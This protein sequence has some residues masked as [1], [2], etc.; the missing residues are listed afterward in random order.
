M[1]TG[2]S[3]QA[4]G[5]A[6]RPNPFTLAAVGAAAGFL[7]G[8]FGIGGG[9]IIVPALVLW[10]AVAQ[11]SATGTSTAAILPTAVVGTISY[12]INGDVDWIAAA[13]L[14]VGVFI[15]AQF[16]SALLAR[17]KVG[18]IQWS[19]MVF[20]LVVI[21]SFWFVIPQRG[22][23]MDLGIWQWLLLVLLGVVTGTLGG[24]LGVGGG[25]IVVP[26]LMVFFGASDLV[27]RGTSLAMMIPGSISG[28]VANV[29]RGNVD[30]FAALIVGLAACV[31]VPVGVLVANSIEPLWANIAFSA[32]LAIILGQML[33]RRLK[34]A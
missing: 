22:D 32:Y 31:L 28:T 25:I 26:M 33:V 17:L 20:L 11:K 34:G 3:D 23:E 12:G 7:S 15:G 29:W 5:I 19:F 16:G 30:L 9:T 8:L 13:C 2:M 1:V 10:L 21:I 6:A 24:V 27:A 18:T 14:A 4:P